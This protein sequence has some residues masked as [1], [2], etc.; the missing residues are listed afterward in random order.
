M[1]VISPSC[2]LIENNTVNL[3][4]VDASGLN[5]G[6]CAYLMDDLERS[7]QGKEVFVKGGYVYFDLTGSYNSVSINEITQKEI[8]DLKEMCELFWDGFC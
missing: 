5:Q 6:Q 1:E 2:L 8:S 3:A 4:D 7:L